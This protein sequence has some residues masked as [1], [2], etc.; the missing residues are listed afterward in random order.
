MSDDK[1]ENRSEN[2][3]RHYLINGEFLL[4]PMIIFALILMSGDPS[5]LDAV[6]H[7]LMKD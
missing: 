6:I 2:P 1:K 7:W 5:L 3:K 4:W